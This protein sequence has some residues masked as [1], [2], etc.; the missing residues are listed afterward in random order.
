[1]RSHIGQPLVADVELVDLTPQDLADVQ[2]R[3]A[4]RDVFQGANVALSPAL[5]GL[6]ISVVKREGR[7]TLHLTTSAPVQSEVLHLYFELSGGGR[8][9]V[10]GV[11]LWLPQAPPAPPAPVPQPTRIVAAPAVSVP[12][13]AAVASAAEPKRAA[14]RSGGVSIQLAAA[15][16]PGKQ[17]TRA[18]AELLG[19]VERAF[20]ARAGRPAAP[21]EEKHSAKPLDKAAA[22]VDKPAAVEKKADQPAQVKAE[23]KGRKAAPKPAEKIVEK[24]AEK[25]AEKPPVA[26]AAKPAPGKM[27][28][29]PVQDPAMLKKLAELEAKLKR[30]QKMVNSAPAAAPAAAAVAVAAPAAPKAVEAAP[31]AAPKA[32][33]AAPP[34]APAQPVAETPG[35][36][37]AGKITD[38]RSTAEAK[39]KSEAHAAAAT[40]AEPIVAQPAHAEPKAKSAEP[41]PAPAPVEE[42][43]KEKKMSRPK[44]LTMIAGGSMALLAL[45][46]V[47]VHFVRRR[48]AKNAKAQIKVWQS[49]RKKAIAEAAVAEEEGAEPASAEAAAEAKAA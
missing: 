38:A 41:K 45:L 19:A 28:Q 9:S 34:A 5:A 39:P 48:N 7:R 36:T 49:W 26:P 30:L 42:P 3:L 43:A 8:Q 12:E 37:A 13:T 46:G 47:I 4:S 16:V 29:P 21:A 32:I 18:D 23:S 44:V 1:M 2:A 15:G 10:R 40:V 33:E 14:G 6:S 20:A 24:P 22:Q 35:R 11:T 27:A 31:P 25:P 17:A